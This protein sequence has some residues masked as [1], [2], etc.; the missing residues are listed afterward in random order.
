MIEIRTKLFVFILLLKVFISTEN[1]QA[2]EVEVKKIET[3]KV[4]AKE[5]EVKEV[6]C[7]GV[8]NIDWVI[9]DR[10]SKCFNNEQCSRYN[11]E[12]IINRSFCF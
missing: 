7:K 2:K 12:F 4:K 1:V 9:V 11:F 5:V 10:A 3:N 8:Y 6:A